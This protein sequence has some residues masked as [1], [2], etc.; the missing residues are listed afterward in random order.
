MFQLLASSMNLATTDY[1]LETV[2][3]S[4][5]VYIIEAMMS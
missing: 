3:A 4:G 1:I 5:I 2:Q